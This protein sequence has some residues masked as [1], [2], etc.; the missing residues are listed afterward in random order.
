MNGLPRDKIAKISPLLDNI[1]LQNDKILLWRQRQK[2]LL[3]DGNN[4]SDDLGIGD[5]IIKRYEQ[6]QQKCAEEVAK[7]DNRGTVRARMLLNASH[8]LLDP[9][10]PETIRNLTVNR[11]IIIG[12]I[13]VYCLRS[14]DQTRLITKML[15]KLPT[16]G[17]DYSRFE[18]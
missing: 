14:K 10:V 5:V 15:G 18:W 17:H 9:N 6:V 4:S 12:L 7:I 16:T 13:S 8:I 1:V 3:N 11:M 2:A